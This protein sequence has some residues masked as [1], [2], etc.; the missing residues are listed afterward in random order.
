MQKDIDDLTEE[1]MFMSVPL[2]ERLSSQRLKKTDQ[3]LVKQRN[4]VKEKVLDDEEPADTRIKVNSIGEV[5]I[6]FTK[7]VKFTKNEETQLL[8][9]L[10]TTVRQDLSGKSDK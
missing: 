8:E 2:R 1:E 10:N 4:F 5:H 3:L 6:V 9:Q 7:K